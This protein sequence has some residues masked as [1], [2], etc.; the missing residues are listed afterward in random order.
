MREQ[1]RTARERAFCA[2]ERILRGAG[3]G[4]GGSGGANER[5]RHAHH[6]TRALLTTRRGA[7]RQATRGGTRERSGR[8][9]ERSDG[10]D[11]ARGGELTFK[12]PLTHLQAIF[13][14]FRT[15]AQEGGY[16]DTPL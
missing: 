3:R 8:Y 7:C 14:C 1:P 6:Y 15:G 9:K 5:K 11:E 12:S 13:V 2:F 10:T 4:H 16:Y